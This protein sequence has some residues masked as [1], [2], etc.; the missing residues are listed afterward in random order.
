M[1]SP[2]W[3]NVSSKTCRASSAGEPIIQGI[4]P[5][6]RQPA[7][8]LAH[9]RNY[10][11]HDITAGVAGSTSQQIL[12]R[13]A[14]LCF[15]VVPARKFPIVLTTR[16]LGPMLKVD[17]LRQPKL[18]FQIFDQLLEAL[19]G[20]G[21]VSQGSRP[22][23]LLQPP[24]KFFSVALF[25]HGDTLLSIR[26]GS[27]AMVHSFSASFWLE[28]ERANLSVKLPKLNVAIDN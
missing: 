22:L 21:V 13:S 14:D 17:L 6:G 7:R 27:G 15:G 19:S 1:V 4:A 12:D 20:D 18:F 16:S 24:L 25:I 8:D 10:L 26:R 23:G 3:R 2:A 28:A 5:L 11:L 9:D